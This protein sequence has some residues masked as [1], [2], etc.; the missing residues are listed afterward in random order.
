MTLRMIFQ[1]W[2]NFD[3]DYLET[4]G[5]FEINNWTDGLRLFFEYISAQSINIKNLL[6]SLIKLII[7]SKSDIKPFFIYLRFH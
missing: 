6:K 2:K 5:L 4:Y 7:S 3:I 1:I